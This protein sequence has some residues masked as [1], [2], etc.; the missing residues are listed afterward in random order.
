MKNKILKISV[1]V[2][3]IIVSVF[4][5]TGCNQTIIDT[6]YTFDR[7]I[8]VLNDGT[9]MEIQ[10]KE[11]TDYSDGEQLQIKGKDGKT[12]LVSSFNTILIKDE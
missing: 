11:W 8:V 2:I 6:N 1:L 9:K 4:V 5:L 10:I 7:A 3:M 12:Y